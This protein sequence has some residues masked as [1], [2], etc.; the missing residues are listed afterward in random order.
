MRTPMWNRRI[1]NTQLESWAELRHDNLL[2][3][4]Q[5]F[6]AVAACEYPDAYVDPYPAFYAAMARMADKGSE[7]AKLWSDV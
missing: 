7:T 6:T 1:L 3:A 5:S 2:Y 4:K